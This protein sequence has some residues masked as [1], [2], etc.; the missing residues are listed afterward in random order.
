[1]N[2][3]ASLVRRFEGSGTSSTAPLMLT[4]IS[5][6]EPCVASD[7]VDVDVDVDVGVDNDVDFTWNR[8]VAE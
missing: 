7:E 4:P 1:M 3:I 5:L 6:M 8:E 2:L